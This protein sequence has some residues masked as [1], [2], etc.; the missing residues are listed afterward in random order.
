MFGFGGSELLVIILVAL[1]V[2]GPQRIPEVARNVSRVYREFHKWR[3][4][5]DGTVSDLRQELNLNLDE[6]LVSIDPASLAVTTAASRPPPVPAPSRPVTQQIEVDALD[7]YL[8]SPA[9]DHSGDGADD[10]ATPEPATSPAA[11][12]ADDYLG[13]GG[14]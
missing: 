2:F 3:R 6:P 12:G 1:L 8:A 14:A 13:G 11:G 9:Y 5:I 10:A 7:D 4:R